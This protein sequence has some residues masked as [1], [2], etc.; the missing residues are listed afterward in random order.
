MID[1]N[2][3]ITESWCSLGAAILF[4]VLGTISMKFS[5]GFTRIPATCAMAMSYFIAFVSMT[6]ALK[7]LD[8]S[9]VYGI[10]SGAGTILVMLLSVLLFNEK[11]QLR[12]LFFLLLIVLGILGIQLA[13][14][15]IND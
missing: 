8:V 9:M 14:G 3:L 13:N 7:T 5:A 11:M 4:G 1:K 10:W 12:K 6:F 2:V 15:F